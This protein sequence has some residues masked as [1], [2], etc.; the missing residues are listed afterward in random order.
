MGRY[1][2]LESNQGSK[3]AYLREQAGSIIFLGPAVFLTI[4]LVNSVRVPV[5]LL[6]FWAE[7]GVVFYSDVINKDFP[8]RLFTDTGA[9]G[10]LNLSGKIIAEFVGLFAIE[11]APIVNFCL[12]NLAYSILFMIIYKRLNQYFQS[13]IYLLLFMGFFVFVPIATFDSLATSINLHFFLLFSIFII[14]FSNQ[15]RPTFTGHLVI[16]I[17]CLSDPLAILLVPAVLALIFLK[18]VR[19]SYL[20]NFFIS[21]TMQLLAILYFFGDSTRSIGNNPSITKTFYLFIDRVVGSTFVPNW[22][23]VDGQNLE[24]GQISRVLIFRFLIGFLILMSILYLVYRSSSISIRQLRMDQNFLVGSLLLTLS[25]YWCVTG[26]F[27]NPE[28]RYAIFPSLC[29]ALV[30]LMG[31]DVVTVNLQN[32]S[33]SKRLI[34][35]AS[36]LFTSIFASAFQ[37]S[38]IRDTDQDWKKQVQVGRAAC[39]G[40]KLLDFK[41]II[42][43][44]RNN[45]TLTIK[46][47]DLD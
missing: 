14:I 18:K 32:A 36:I 19:N 40:E 3:L 23:F 7:D 47:K 17:T 22:G 33:S 35:I 42:P 46:C 27:F 11:I 10:Y 41:V 31:L 1:Q 2:N 6:N 45:L 34:G 9:G 5:G 21:L 8:Q 37:V 24:S 16:F 4:L 30:F 43:P 12:V 29:L 39:Y 13:K 28:P 44:E 15:I 25:T 20:L 26:I 38:E